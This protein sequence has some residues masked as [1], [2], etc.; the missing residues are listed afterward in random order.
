MDCI[1]SL[2]TVLPAMPLLLPKRTGKSFGRLY[3]VMLTTPLVRWEQYGMVIVH[4][5]GAAEAENAHQSAGVRT[6]LAGLAGV[7]ARMS[8]SPNPERPGPELS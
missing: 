1:N 8:P 6:A 7:G 2:D 4:C 3:D 5:S